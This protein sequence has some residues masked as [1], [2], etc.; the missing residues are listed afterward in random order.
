MKITEWF[1]FLSGLH[2]SE[3]PWRFHSFWT[4]AMVSMVNIWLGIPF[5]MVVI[6]GGMQSISPE[7]YDAAVVDGASYS[8]NFRYITLPLLK[9][10]L[11]PVILLGS[12]W[13]FNSINVVYLMTGGLGAGAQGVEY[14]DLILTAVYKA[15]FIYFNYS[16][17]AAL[18]I[19]IVIVLLIFTIIW[20][21]LTRGTEKVY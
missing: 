4:F 14:A 8:Q 7:Y 1:P 3:I 18:G 20:L 5:C 11:V 21:R 12:I 9:P 17:G 16:L 19:I 2:L 10:V 6:L 13:T 15:S